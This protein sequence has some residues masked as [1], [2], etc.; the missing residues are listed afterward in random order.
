M[1][2]SKLFLYYDLF[3]REGGGGRMVVRMGGGMGDGEECGEG[4]LERRIFLRTL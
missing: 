2:R 1:E 4:S 3:I